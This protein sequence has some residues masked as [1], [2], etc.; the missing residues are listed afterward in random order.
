[1]HPILQKRFE[2]LEQRKQTF[3]KVLESSTLQQYTFKPTPKAWNMLEVAQHLLQ[4]E[5]GLFALALKNV[6]VGQTTVRSKFGYW[7]ILATFKTP[8]KVKVPDG[9]KA[10]L[11]KAGEILE[12]KNVQSA[13]E[14]IH[15]Q[16]R[17]YLEPQSVAALSKPVTRHPFVDPM[18]LGQMLG[19]FD[20]HIA[21]HQHQLKR[22]Q[23]AINF[24]S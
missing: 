16:L 20:V 4:A 17:A 1:M 6:D 15:D 13:W 5:R 7:F 12:L 18:T 10:A 14:N 19:F 21:H 3:M 22:I 8:L 2:T 23:T 9:A 24:P 11:P